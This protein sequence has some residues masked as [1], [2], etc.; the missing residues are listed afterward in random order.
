MSTIFGHLNLNDNDRVFNATQGQRVIYDAIQAYV[1]TKNAEMNAAYGVFVGETTA[2]YKERYKLPGGGYMQEIDAAQRPDAVKNYGSWDVAY[3]LRNYADAVAGSRVD[4]AYM[5][6]QELENNV[7][8]VM[9]RSINITRRELLRA[10]LYKEDETFVDPLWGSLT[11]KG[12][13]TGSTDGVLYPPLPGATAEAVRQRYNGLNYI[14]SAIDDSHNPYET[15]ADALTADFGQ[16]Q[17]NSN[18]A[19]FINSAQKAKTKALGDFDEL[20]DRFVVPGANVNQLTG[21]PANLPGIIIGR[22]SGCW[23]VQWDFMPSG[24]LLG[25]HL[26]APAPLKKRIDPADTGLGDGLQLVVGDESEYPL[27]SSYWQ[28]RFGFGV[29]NRLNGYAA[30]L[31]GSTTYTSPTIS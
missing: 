16:Q 3:P 8:G 9:N 14:A 23:V 17:G 7:I 5:T 27:V 2:N 21:L 19:V 22:V 28:N 31:V 30:Q 11:V 20:N 4:R 10:L 26:D 12:L 24:Y 6:A 25:V 15:I 18:V 13:A 1:N 29:G